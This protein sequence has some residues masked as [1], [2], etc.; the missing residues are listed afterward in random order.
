MSSIH[1]RPGQH[2]RTSTDRREIIAL[3][4]P[5]SCLKLRFL[6]FPLSRGRVRQPWIQTSP[7]T[8]SWEERT[9]PRRLNTPCARTWRPRARQV[10]RWTPAKAGSRSLPMITITDYRICDTSPAAL[11][12]S[13]SG[14]AAP[15]PGF[16][17]RE[18]P[19][20]VLPHVQGPADPP[21]LV[22]RRNPPS[23][24]SGVRLD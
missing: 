23:H 15:L 16:P 17:N 4:S 9:L 2:I 10:R 5:H 19:L 1:R 7:R 14:Q 11:R 8:R 6:H 3:F 18:S 24:L 21:R 13:T 12:E 22:R 20:P